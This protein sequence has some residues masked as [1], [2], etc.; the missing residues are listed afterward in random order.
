MTKWTTF[1][2]EVV[3]PL[4]S[5]DDRA[6]TDS[7]IRVPSIRGAL[8][9]WFR[10]VATGH[11][12]DDLSTLAKEES[13]IFGDTQNP[14]AIRMR[15]ISQLVAGGSGTEPAWAKPRSNGAAR[16]GHGR[17]RNE[18]QFNGVQYLLGQGL[19]SH[20]DRLTRPFVE[21]G[22]RFELQ[23]RLTDHDEQVNSRFLLAMWAW[24]TYGGL[25]SRVRRGFGQ[26]RCVEVSG[27]TRNPLLKAMTERPDW[28]ALGESAIPRS[29]RDE[30]QIG[31]STW[32]GE[33]AGDNDTMPAHPMLAPKWWGGV[34]FKD[35]L[36]SFGEALDLAGQKWRTFRLGDHPSKDLPP[37]SPGRSPEWVKSIQGP[38][39]DFPI[40]ALGLPVGY[41]SR[42]GS[43]T[44][45]GEIS[46]EVKGGEGLRRASPVWLRPVHLSRNEWGIFTHVFYAQ[47]LPEGA[48]LVG[49]GSA[50]NLQLKLPPDES[51]NSAESQLDRW[52][53]NDVRLDD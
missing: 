30:R 35:R 8:R 7:P 46:A 44:F 10:A 41:Y 43:S 13:E 39:N 20:R 29:L 2:L 28:E 52:L 49:T 38:N 16:G 12:V 32:L 6:S 53:D 36:R 9:Y 15:V 3:T 47:V 48:G 21:P 19:W 17:D 11:G 45:K 50:I 23:V 1:H 4:F 22:G 42:K 33:P 27:A 14:S 34:L 40:G 26:L 24:L 51:A 25:G 5:G 18:G 37:P 31:W